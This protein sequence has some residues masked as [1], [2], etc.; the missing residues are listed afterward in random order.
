M[1]AIVSGPERYANGFRVTQPESGGAGIRAQS[2]A[3]VHPCYIHLDTPTYPYMYTQASMDTIHVCAQTHGQHTHKDMDAAQE[4][5]CIYNTHAHT[6]HDGHSAYTNTRTHTYTM[7]MHALTHRH[8]SKP[9]ARG[10]TWLSGAG[11][12]L[13]LRPWEHQLPSSLPSRPTDV[14][15][16]SGQLARCAPWPRMSQRPRG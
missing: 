13:S 14:C 8:I 2:F 16:G 11:P 6:T 15:C 12:G 9:E 4:H 1:G 7:C 10:L 5:I 3:A